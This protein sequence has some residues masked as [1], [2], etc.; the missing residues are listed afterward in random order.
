MLGNTK[1]LPKSPLLGLA[2]IMI[3]ATV[4]VVNVVRSPYTHHNLEPEG[5]D[6]TEV[7]TLGDQHPYEGIPLADPELTRTGDPVRDGRALFFGN[8]C[9]NCHGLSGQGAVVGDE[10]DLEELADL[11][12]DVRRG[13]KGMP[14]FSED[15]ISEEELQNIFA[16]LEASASGDS[17]ASTAEVNAQ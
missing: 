16:F 7:A 15:V 5:Y 9:A 1:S 12:K 14:A 8:G 17:N 3:M 6:R 13:E 2:V 4:A 10:I 11:L